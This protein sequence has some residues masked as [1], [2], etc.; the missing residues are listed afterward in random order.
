MQQSQ[1][2]LNRN[3]ESISSTIQ[4]TENYACVSVAFLVRRAQATMLATILY[5]ESDEPNDL[6]AVREIWCYPS[7]RLHFISNQERNTTPYRILSKG[8]YALGIRV[9]LG[10]CSALLLEETP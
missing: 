5:S 4:G 7:E 6:D 9:V 3:R 1:A 10:V 2:V 8:R